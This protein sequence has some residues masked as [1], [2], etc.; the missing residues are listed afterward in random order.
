MVGRGGRG[1][2]FWTKWVSRSKNMTVGI[3]RPF[4]NHIPTPAHSE[5]DIF[6]PPAVANVYSSHTLTCDFSFYP[7]AIVSAF[8][9]KFSLIFCLSSPFSPFS[10]FSPRD[11]RPIAPSPSCFLVHTVH[12]CMATLGTE[13]LEKDTYCTGTRTLRSLP[14]S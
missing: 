13:E 9:F 5:N 4:T 1:G 8:Q 10:Y 3:F 6:S 11:H 7:F 2:M 14:L 12:Y